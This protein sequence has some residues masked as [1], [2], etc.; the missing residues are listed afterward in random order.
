[1]GD[2]SCSSFLYLFERVDA[3][4]AVEIPNRAGVLQKWTDKGFVGAFLHSFVP[5]PLIPSKEAQGLV[6]L[7]DY[8]GGDPTTHCCSNQAEMC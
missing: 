6:G 4:V 2:P 3:G 1:M 8:A 5:Q 7:A